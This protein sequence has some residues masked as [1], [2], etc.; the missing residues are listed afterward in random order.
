[1]K[2]VILKLLIIQFRQLG[3]IL[4]TTPVISAIKADYP[5]F[6]VDVVTYPMGN[7]ILAGNPEI[8]RHWVAPQTGVRAT[9]RFIREIRRQ[10]Y[11]AV[12]DFMGT[13][14][15]VLLALAIKANRKITFSSK[16]SRFFSDIVPRGVAPDYIVREKFQLLG[17]LGIKPGSEQLSLP[18]N[19]SDAVVAGKF[20]GDHS[21]VKVSRRRVMLSPTHRRT[22]RKWPKSS[23]VEL[24][25]WLVTEENATVIWVWGPGEE[26]EIDELNY[27]S[28]GLG[29]KTPKASFKELAALVAATDLFICNSN[30]PSHVSVAVNTPSIQLHGTTSAICWCPMSLRHRGMQG[31]A[32][33]DISV[34][35]V[36]NVIRDMWPMVDDGANKLRKH[37]LI[38]SDR[39]ALVVRP[40][41]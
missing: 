22:E 15:S 25:R 30:G 2:V 5:E 19:S 6:N 35:A 39:E 16:R 24:A 23:W 11:D 8:H 31:V 27:L 14:R 18:W 3:D 29:V 1:V 10:H 20:L 36:R 34:E 33:A 40:D 12:I 41:L 28:G 26:Q 4:L 13:P 37:G 21:T 7:L 32:I 9:I 17:P 38:T